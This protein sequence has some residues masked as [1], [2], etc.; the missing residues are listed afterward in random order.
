M[1]LKLVWIAVSTNILSKIGVSFICYSH[2]FR[3]DSTY[4][5]TQKPT[6]Q[7]TP[8][9]ENGR[10]S[11]NLMNTPFV[12]SMKKLWWL[13]QENQKQVCR[14]DLLLLAKLNVYLYISCNSKRVHQSVQPSGRDPFVVGFI[15]LSPSRRNMQ[16]SVTL[17]SRDCNYT[18]SLL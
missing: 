12:E 15:G 18:F 2:G 7:P 14:F 10:F 3:N 16:T 8:D 17:Q 11:N 4:R 9:K 13:F 6:E 1:I 5:V